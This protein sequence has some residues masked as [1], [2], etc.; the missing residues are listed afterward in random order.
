MGWYLDLGMGGVAVV[1]HDPDLQRNLTG[2]E[3][4]AQQWPACPVCGVTVD[5]VSVRTSD[6]SGGPDY[7]IPERAWCPRGHDL[8][9]ALT[10][11]E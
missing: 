9:A 1:K 11:R 5:V 2:G 10:L 6:A 7:Y 8:G 4:R 3:L